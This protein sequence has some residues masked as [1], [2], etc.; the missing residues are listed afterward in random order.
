MNRLR[1]YVRRAEVLWQAEQR[2]QQSVVDRLKASIASFDKQIEEARRLQGGA[3]RDEVIRAQ[4][5]LAVVTQQHREAAQVVTESSAQSAALQGQLDEGRKQWQAARAAIENAAEAQTQ[6]ER[7]ARSCQAAQS[8]SLSLYGREVP[9]I[10]TAISA[11]RWR[12]QP[13][14]Q[15]E[16]CRTDC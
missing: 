13:V 8:G 6:A 4:K 3:V 7:I 9:N 16:C 14:R 2:Q 12:V 1:K 5:E 11:A 15:A 10:L